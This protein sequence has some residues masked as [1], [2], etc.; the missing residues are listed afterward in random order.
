MAQS[1]F[2]HKMDFQAIGARALAGDAHFFEDST[3]PAK[4]RSYLESSKVIH[5]PPMK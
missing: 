2:H 5:F 1:I 3:S 4:V